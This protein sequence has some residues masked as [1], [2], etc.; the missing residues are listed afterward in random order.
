MRRFATKSTETKLVI[1]WISG[2]VSRMD[3]RWAHACGA[4]LSRKF[5]GFS[6][7]LSAIVVLS[8]YLSNAENLNWMRE[9]ENYITMYVCMYV[10][11]SKFDRHNS[12]I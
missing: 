1:H 2:D 5:F 6:S 11:M 8:Q 7:I 10:G 4:Q 9:K 12:T 3:F